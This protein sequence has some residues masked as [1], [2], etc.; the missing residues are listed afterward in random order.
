[1]KSLKEVRIYSYLD[2]GVTESQDTYYGE[3]AAL[4]FAFGI[5]GVVTGAFTKEELADYGSMNVYYKYWNTTSEEIT[6]MPLRTCVPADFGLD[7][8]HKQ[9]N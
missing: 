3:E 4:K 6:K 8:T 5:T 2:Y 9:P 7:D 1:M